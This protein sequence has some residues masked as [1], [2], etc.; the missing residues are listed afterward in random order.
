MERE[1]ETDGW[2]T[3]LDARI[4]GRREAV[5]LALRQQLVEMPAREIYS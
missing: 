4:A 3:I 5:A 1:T 2:P